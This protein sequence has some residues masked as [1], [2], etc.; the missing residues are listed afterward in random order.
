MHDWRQIAQEGR[1]PGHLSPEHRDEIVAELAS[2]LEGSYN[3][4]LAHHRGGPR[5]WRLVRQSLRAQPVEGLEIL[6]LRS[7]SQAARTPSA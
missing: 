6:I 1:E 4:V 7:I 2:H 5:L 3:E